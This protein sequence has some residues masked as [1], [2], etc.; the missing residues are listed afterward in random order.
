MHRA[1]LAAQCT[2]EQWCIE[3]FFSQKYNN[4]STFAKNLTDF[5]L[6]LKNSIAELTLLLKDDHGEFV[7][8]QQCK[9]ATRV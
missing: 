8:K 5:D 6:P 7:K 1:E 2:V 4:F 3:F 9:K